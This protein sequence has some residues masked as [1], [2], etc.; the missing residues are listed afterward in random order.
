MGGLGFRVWISGEGF[1]VGEL[2]G[3]RKEG[4][5]FGARQRPHCNEAWQ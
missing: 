1:A 2:R 5:G 4:L 3:F